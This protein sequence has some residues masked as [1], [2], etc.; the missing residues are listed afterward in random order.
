MD[1]MDDSYQSRGHKTKIWN[2]TLGSLLVGKAW[3]A[4][5]SLFATF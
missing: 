1:G 4:S 2:V 5:R 3:P